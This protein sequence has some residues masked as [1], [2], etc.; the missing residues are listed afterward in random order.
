[1]ELYINSIV[2]YFGYNKNNPSEIPEKVALSRDC[3]HLMPIAEISYQEY[4]DHVNEY[5]E[6]FQGN[7]IFFMNHGLIIME[8]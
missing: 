4:Q 7:I 1:M 2:P 5:Y 6:S 8:K 3:A